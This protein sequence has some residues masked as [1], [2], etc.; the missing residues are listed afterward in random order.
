MSCGESCRAVE[1]TGKS[2]NS[3]GDVLDDGADGSVDGNL[4][5]SC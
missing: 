1:G 4:E 2:V 5:K 3:V